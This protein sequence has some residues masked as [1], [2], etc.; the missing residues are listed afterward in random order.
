MRIRF[1]DGVLHQDDLRARRALEAVKTMIDEGRRVIIK[2]VDG[3]N[4][5]SE[6]FTNSNNQSQVAQSELEDITIG[7]ARR[8]TDRDMNPSRAPSDEARPAVLITEDRKMRV[9][10]N[11]LKVAA[12]ASSFLSKVIVGARRRSISR[13]P[14][15]S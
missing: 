7:L 2:N 9:K 13:E 10:A 14:G 3:K 8:E 11:G 1:L 15:S 4:V 6:A 12:I 5:T